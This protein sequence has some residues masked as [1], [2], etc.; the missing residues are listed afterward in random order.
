[1][2]AEKKNI[3][4]DVKKLKQL[5]EHLREYA[6]YIRD[7]EKQPLASEIVTKVWSWVSSNLRDLDL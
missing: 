4:D 6:D 1:M 7:R 3:E 2:K 5:K